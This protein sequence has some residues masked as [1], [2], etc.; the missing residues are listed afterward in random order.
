M[1]AV[2][3]PAKATDTGSARPPIAVTSVNPTCMVAFC[4]TAGAAPADAVV[5]VAAVAA[6]GASVA[7]SV[8]ATSASDPKAMVW[9]RRRCMTEPPISHD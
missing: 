8:E 5:A 2:P 6:I 9:V 4:A 3:S 1:N 7:I